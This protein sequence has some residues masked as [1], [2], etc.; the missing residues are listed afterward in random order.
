MRN[1]RLFI[2][3]FLLVLSFAIVSCGSGHKEFVS[4]FE[5]AVNSHNVEDVLSFYDR[6]VTVNMGRQSTNIDREDMRPL[7]EWDSIVNTRIRL[8]IIRE[9]GDSIIGRKIEK[10]EWFRLYGLDSVIFDPWI[11]LVEDDVITTIFSQLTIE[12]A[13]RMSQASTSVQE[14]AMQERRKDLNELMPEGSFRYGTEAAIRWLKL[15]REW[16]KATGQDQ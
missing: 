4:K 1:S 2:F 3:I 11:V 12:S 16:R 14:W 5:A 6:D 15:L 9:N 13:T 10:S 8:D 7:A